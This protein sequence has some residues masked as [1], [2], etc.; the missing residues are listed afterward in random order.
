MV[1]S[2]PGLLMD[3]SY[4]LPAAGIRVEGVPDDVL[5]TARDAGHETWVCDI[6]VFEVLAEGAKF[7]ASG[8]V[9]EERLEIAVQAILGDENLRKVRAYE[10]EVVRTSISLRRLHRDFVD[11]LIIASALEHCEGLVSEE[12]FRQEPG[13]LRFI[14]ERRHGFRLLTAKDLAR[15]A[16]RGGK[17]GTW[18]TDGAVAGA[19]PEIKV[20]IPKA[21]F[22]GTA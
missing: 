15:E 1:G 7:A 2:L 13:L 5:R 20:H 4:L 9:D 17:A 10:P 6:S 16:R 19:K 8:K 18:P 22:E 12:D 3:T 21:V 14:E 11:C